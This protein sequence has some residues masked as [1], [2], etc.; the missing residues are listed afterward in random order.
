M[1]HLSTQLDLNARS[2]DIRAY[3]RLFSTIILTMQVA[4]LVE[5]LSFVGDPV[6]ALSSSANNYMPQVQA[7]TDSNIMALFAI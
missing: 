3:S 4:M 7:R 6:T 1:D 5:P 2:H